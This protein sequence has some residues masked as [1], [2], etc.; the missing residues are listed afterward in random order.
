MEAY[1]KALAALTGIP[2]G[3]ISL[4]LVFTAPAECVEL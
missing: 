4:L 1:R 2:Q 3:T